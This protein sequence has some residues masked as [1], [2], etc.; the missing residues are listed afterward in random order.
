[1]HDVDLMIDCFV[2]CFRICPHNN[3]ALK[4]C[5]APNA[6]VVFQYVLISSLFRYVNIQGLTFV[7]IKFFRIVSQPR[8]PWWPEIDIMY[9]KSCELRSMFTETLNKV[10]QGCISHPTLRM[11]PLVRYRPPILILTS[12]FFLQSLTLK[13]KDSASKYRERNDEWPGH[14]GLLFLMVRLIH[15]DPMLMLNVRESKIVKP[16]S[17]FFI[18]ESRKN[19]SRNSELNFGTNQRLGESCSSTDHARRGS[20]SHGSSFGPPPP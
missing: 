1:M 18:S 7:I 9:N 6:P 19:G 20:R 11:I 16:I 8:L 17:N 14:K 15:A 2:S 4:V 13:S 5:L 3:E 10:A 12:G